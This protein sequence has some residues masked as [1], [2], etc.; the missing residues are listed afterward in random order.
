MPFAD[1]LL[2]NGLCITMDE[3]L[4]EA[5]AL[6]ICG[7][8]IAWVGDESQ[9]QTW[10]GPQTQV[11]NL[12]GAYVYPGFIDT[13]AH[14]VPLGLTKNLHL[15]LR[16]LSDK[17]AVLQK[18]K[19][20]VLSSPPGQW[21]LGIGW[22]EDSWPEK[23]LPCAADLDR[24]APDNPVLLIRIDTHSAWVNSLA[25]KGAGIHS[26]TPDPEGG[27]IYRNG[28]GKPSGILLDH[29]MHLVFDS[30]PKPDLEETVQLTRH[31]LEDCLKTGITMIH[32]AVTP[33]VDWEALK[34]LAARQELPIRVYAMALIPGAVGEA[35]IKST[36][37]HFGSFLEM[38]C[39]KFFMDGAMGSR[40]AA[41]L[42]D[43]QDDPGNKGLILWKRE[44]LL[45]MLS[46]AKAAGF[47]VAF[48][49][50][51]DRANREV[52]D[53]Y[54]QVDAA[55]LRWR[56]EHVQLITPEDMGRLAALDII[57]AMQ[58][59]HLPADMAWFADRVG[60]TRA[61]QGAFAWR[62]LLDHGVRIAGG[63]DAP[64]V[65]VNPL[66]GIYAACTR[67]DLQGNPAEGW[68][69]EQCVTRKEALR[70][71][72]IDAA[73]SCYREHELGSLTPGKLADV[74][75]LPEH[76][77]HCHVK[78]LIDMPVLYTIVNGCVHKFA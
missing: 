54:E 74:V 65:E 61:R 73:Y 47:Q 29:A 44:D 22:D 30:M 13:H 8:R 23:K 56:I 25:L 10:I 50:I 43:Y 7:D 34:I 48:H 60:E 64:V 17:E 52:L 46:Q 26:G 31:V 45:P 63:S 1:I 3:S 41:M 15:N 9:C 53:A 69:P 5:T 59:L 49:A 16:G 32:N 57:A 2:R 28:D 78:A 37:L 4:P 42:E 24:V 39:I 75:V 35:L 71:Y 38:R 18:I 55:G 19:G 58:P 67:Q 11:I 33:E 27:K 72:T 66:L 76:L 20:E 51:G 36:P 70:M 68:Y 21:I 12:Q 77:L 40:G 6:A 62:A 14:I